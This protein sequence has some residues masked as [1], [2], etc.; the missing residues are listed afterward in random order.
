MGLHPVNQHVPR[1]YTFKRRIRKLEGNSIDNIQAME[2]GGYEK[3]YEL[4]RSKNSSPVLNHRPEKW[5]ASTSFAT[6][7][8]TF[9]NFRKHSES[10]SNRN[11]DIDNIVIPY[12]VAASTRPEVL[13]YKEIPTPKWVIQNDWILQNIN[14]LSI[15]WRTITDDD[16]NDQL[17]VEHDQ[18]VHSGENPEDEDISD[19][20][21][22]VQHD[23]ALLEER[24][25]FET[26]LKFPLTS[27]SRANRRIDSRGNE[28][29]GANT[30]TIDPTSP[31]P[32]LLTGELEVK[33]SSINDK[34]GF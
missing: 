14:F 30:P 34:E 13:S 27:R 31:A 10:R 24:K 25:K 8:S 20:N 1:K 18:C 16:E 26:Y 17:F 33:I 32:A 3:H 15:R 28:S 29:S 19:E 9:N 23:K 11:Y 22:V 7:I 2:N 5:V 12:S 4:I 6:F 21:L